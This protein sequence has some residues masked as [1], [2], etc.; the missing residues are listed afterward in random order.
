LG[1][2]NEEYGIIVS[3]LLHDMIG[4]RIFENKKTALGQIKV[5]SY[6]EKSSE[7]F[8]SDYLIR[9]NIKNNKVISEKLSL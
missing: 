7:P 5:E 2:K 8:K 1:L 6:I 9:I 3:E 4:Y